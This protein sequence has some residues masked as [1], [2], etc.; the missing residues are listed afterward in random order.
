MNGA[1]DVGTP[2]A[3]I[4][5]PGADPVFLTFKA[6]AD[7]FAIMQKVFD[8]ID[9]AVGAKHRLDKGKAGGD[10]S[11]TSS[12]KQQQYPN[13]PGQTLDA[14]PSCAPSRKPDNASGVVQPIPST[15]PGNP[16]GDA[17]APTVTP[18]RPA[19]VRDTSMA[20][21]RALEWSGKLGEQEQT[22]VDFFLANPNP[23]GWTRQELSRRVEWKGKPMPINA[24]CGRVNALLA[25]P[26]NVL[27]ELDTKKTCSVTANRVNALALAVVVAETTA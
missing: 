11:V 3:Y 19:G 14:V 26:F 25:E 4:G 23:D 12:P 24:V 16:P 21:Y 8:G 20:A 2:A 9:A 5:L 13:P 7:P 1:P 18:S 27:V 17:S 6:K 15:P 22:V 10:N